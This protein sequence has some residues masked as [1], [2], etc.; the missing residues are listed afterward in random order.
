MKAY[1][2]WFPFV[3]LKFVQFDCLRFVQLFFSQFVQ[4]FCSISVQLFCLRFAQYY[5]LPHVFCKCLPGDIPRSNFF[6]SCIITLLLSTVMFTTFSKIS[7]LCSIYTAHILNSLLQQSIY[8]RMYR[9]MERIYFIS[10]FYIFTISFVFLVVVS[11]AVH[12]RSF[13]E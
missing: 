4:L 10:E 8:T 5:Y 1:F 7:V 12:M 6:L 9:F 11:C 2:L 13:V 3:C